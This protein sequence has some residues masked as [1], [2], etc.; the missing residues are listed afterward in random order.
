M[1]DSNPEFYVQP[2]G[3][4]PEEHFKH[5]ESTKKRILQAPVLRK[6]LQGVYQQDEGENGERGGCSNGKQEGPRR[7]PGPSG[8]EWSVLLESQTLREKETLQKNKMGMLDGRRDRTVAAR[9][10]YGSGGKPERKFLML[11]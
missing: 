7:S 10:V 6:S 9:G 4:S 1:S 2:H 11:H 5:A 3:A 8:R